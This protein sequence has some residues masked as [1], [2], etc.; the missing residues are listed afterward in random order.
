MRRRLTWLA[1]MT[2]AI[3]LTGLFQASPAWAT[4]ANGF[5]STP[6]AQGQFDQFNVFNRFVL[7]G[8]QVWLSRQW[9]KGLSDGSAL[10]NVWQP[11]GSTGWHSH[12]GHSLIIV[13]SGTLTNYESDDPECKPHVYTKGMSFVDS[14]GRHVHIIRNEGTMVATNIAVQ[15]IPAGAMRRIDAGAPANCPNIE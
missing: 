12:P 13:T 2:A 4:P 10:L 8:S 14:G 11:G 5:T 7:P 9:T 15:L 1:V 6:L 3:V